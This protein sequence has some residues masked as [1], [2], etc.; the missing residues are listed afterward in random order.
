[1]FTLNKQE[2]YLKIFY[3][4]ILQIK[5]KIT[6]IKKFIIIVTEEKKN[7][8]EITNITLFFTW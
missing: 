7:I 5:E 1:M 2:M 8:H 3:V 6:S 4:N